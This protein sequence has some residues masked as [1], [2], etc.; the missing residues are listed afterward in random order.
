MQPSTGIGFGMF[1]WLIDSIADL[2][3]FLGFKQPQEEQEIIFIILATLLTSILGG[4]YRLGLMIYRRRQENRLKKDLHP[5]FSATDIRKAT[6]FYVPTHFQSNPPSQH[7]ELIQAHKVTARQRLLPFFLKQAFKPDQSDQ[8]FYMVL[9]GSGMGKTT[10]MINLYMRYLA[11]QRWGKGKFHIRLLP[12]GY[13]DLLDRIEEIPDQPNTILLLDGLDEDSQAVKDYKKRLNR[14]LKRVR[15][16]RVVIF[17]CRTQF[18]PSEEEEPKETGVVKFGSKQGFQT[19]AKMYL[20]P[21]NETDIKRYL[22]KKYG[23]WKNKK[24]QKAEQIILQSPNLIV[25]PMILSY[26]DDLLEE[27]RVYQY[28]S[29]LY[30]VLI[31]KWI[32]REGARV[33]EDRRTHFEE[34]LYRFSK[35]VALNIYQNQK[36]RKGLFINEKDIRQ[37]AEKHKIQLG[38]IEMKSRSLLNRNVLGQYKFAHKSILEY[39]LAA[40]ATDNAKFR[41]QFNFEGMDQ[42]KTFFDEL[43]LIRHTMPLFQQGTAEGTYKTTGDTQLPLSQIK[44][45][46]LL[47]ITWLSFSRFKQIEA[48]SPLKRLRT[49]E[50]ENTQV[51]DLGA[52]IGL[53]KLEDLN[54]SQT[55]IDDIELLSRLDALRKLYMDHCPVQDLRALRNV[56]LSHLSLAFTKVEDLS[57]ISGLADLVSIS[58]HHTRVRDIN[59][60]RKLHALT[61]LTANN[62]LVNSLSPLREL[63]ALNHLALG[64]TKVQ[65]LSPVR[66]LLQLKH[67][68]CNH[69]SISDL[70][71]IKD[72]TQLKDLTLD[73]CPVSDLQPLENME[74]LEKLHI[75]HSRVKD[76]S[77]LESFSKLRVLSLQGTEVKDL[78]PVIKLPRL[79][80]LTLDEGQIDARSLQGFKE[81]RPA[82]QVI[83]KK[84]VK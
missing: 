40:E 24:K 16:F 21:F 70:K 50:L 82:C 4:L 63:T 32:A 6:Q 79:K 15:D 19:F 45:E 12:L 54:I 72:L 76:I 9:A 52:L 27:T 26:I 22:R 62:T 17:T 30:E 48:L 57:P 66:H 84:R 18:F 61:A 67:L 20:A 68:S 69:T 34:E 13:P 43:C 28:T 81:A 14:I 41:V 11:G 75:S 29:R 1:R 46:E 47:Q 55:Q 71:P 49:L 7:S 73:R 56:N 77:V 35:E 38:D 2:L 74:T 31:R 80:T 5:Y 33:A 78:R 8:R 36:H 23:W 59:P 10:F 39:F 25:R 53:E 37:F 44:S 65:S 42:A 51:R 64:Y 60:L 3:G 83:L 58:F